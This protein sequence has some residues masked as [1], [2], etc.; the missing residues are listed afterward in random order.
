M[1]LTTWMIY[2]RGHIGDGAAGLG[3]VSCLSTGGEQ[4]HQAK[5]RQL[6]PDIASALV[7]AAEDVVRLEVPVEDVL[8]LEGVQVLQGTGDVTHAPP[9]TELFEKNTVSIPGCFRC[10]MISECSHLC[11]LHDDAENPAPV[12]G[13]V[14]EALDDVLV[15]QALQ[16]LGLLQVFPVIVLYLLHSTGGAVP[17]FLVH[18]PKSSIP[19][20]LACCLPHW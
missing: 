12:L 11:K 20:V 5:V 7:I 2:L 16:G 17:H 13:V 9:D 4:L 8:R 1:A 3:V 15:V 19:K 10:D 14:T 6:P 18:L